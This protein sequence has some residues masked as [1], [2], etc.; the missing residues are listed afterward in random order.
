MIGDR[1][2][3]DI[4]GAHAVGI[5]SL[6]VATGVH[7]AHDLAQAPKDERPTYIAAGPR[8]RWREKQPGRD[9]RRQQAQLRRL[10][11]PRS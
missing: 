8:A 11:A 7:D 3:S 2:D 1:L 6:W 10:D 9:G 4:A 5:A